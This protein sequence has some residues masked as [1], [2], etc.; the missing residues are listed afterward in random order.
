MS[1]K[2][3]RLSLSRKRKRNT[4]SY[5]P[6][7]EVLD[8]GE[9]LDSVSNDIVSRGEAALSELHTPLCKGYAERVEN[10]TLPPCTV[11][12]EQ[13]D[14]K[15]AHCSTNSDV[16]HSLIKKSDCYMDDFE[17]YSQDSRVWNPQSVSENSILSKKQTNLHSF[18]PY[19]P[20]AQ[21]KLHPTSVVTEATTSSQRENE[22]QNL[23]NSDTHRRVKL[24]KSQSSKPTETS[25]DGVSV[26]S[27]A[28]SLD[29][30][31]LIVG[32]TR[33]PTNLDIGMT[34]V[35]RGHSARPG[36]CVSSRESTPSSSHQPQRN[37]SGA[38]KSARKKVCPQYK[39]IP[40]L[41]I[42]LLMPS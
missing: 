17:I 23:F 8:V 33:M 4:S 31:H 12:S 35:T 21:R 29:R 36:R 42:L 25:V 20:A 18:F 16:E 39:W 2:C 11:S 14:S 19:T 1:A 32:T 41:F 5:S 37:Q 34:M 40:G 26:E 6:Q 7:V 10:T 9:D 38:I 13:V 15:H 3:H 30:S 22:M 24:G 27:C 28:V